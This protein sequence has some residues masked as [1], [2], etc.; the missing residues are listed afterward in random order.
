[1]IERY[2]AELNEALCGPRTVK[3]DL[4]AEARDGLID[5]AEAYEETGLDRASAERRAVADFG[6][7]AT[8]APDYQTELA[9]A[10]GR[11]TAVLI[12]AV[13][14]IQPVAWW[15][16]LSLV[17]HGTGTANGAGYDLVNSVVRW[18]GG[19]AIGTALA[20]A[21]ATGSG[22]RHL[23]PRR[24][25]VRAAGFFAFA[26]CAVFAVLGALLTFYSTAA[27]SLLGVTGLPM[28]ALLLGIPLV[29]IA[30]SGRRCLTAA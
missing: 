10:Q 17:G 23:G 15:M 28:T 12:C 16:L 1:M 14:T 11:R 24:G 18:T 9:L 22:V 2:V 20:V 25:L 26:V 13:L 27:E 19:G 7:V 29:A 30:V 4:L 21:I 6:P 8:V 5:A 3:A